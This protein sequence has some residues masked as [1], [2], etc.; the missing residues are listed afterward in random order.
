MFNVAFINWWHC[1]VFKR[2][3]ITRVCANGQIKKPLWGHCT[4][5]EPRELPFIKWWHH[6]EILR[7]YETK[8]CI[9]LRYVFTIFC[10]AIEISEN[11][12]NWL[13]LLEIDYDIVTKRYTLISV[14]WIRIENGNTSLAPHFLYKS[15]F[16]TLHNQFWPLVHINVLFGWGSCGTQCTKR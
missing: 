2:H 12:I 8:S 5:W 9:E 10:L 6:D 14:V 4:W 13:Q 3:V 7:V 16:A 1:Y 11:L 15:Q